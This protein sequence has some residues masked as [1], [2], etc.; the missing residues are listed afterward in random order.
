LILWFAIALV[1]AVSMG[2]VVTVK[3]GEAYPRLPD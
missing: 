1:V 3:S 2:T